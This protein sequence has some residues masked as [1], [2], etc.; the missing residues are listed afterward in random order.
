MISREYRELISKCG[1]IIALGGEHLVSLPLIEAQHEKHGTDLFVVQFDAHAD[2]RKEYLGVSLTH[3][4]VM[5]KA[6]DLIG[7]ERIAA[8]GIRSGTD[9]EWAELRNHPHVFGALAPRPL[10]AFPEFA[11]KHLKGRKVYLTIDLDV[12]D[13][14]CMPGT[15]TPE[16]GGISFGDAVQILRALADAGIDIVGADIVELAPDY[17]HSGIS[18]ALAAT[19]LRELILLIGLP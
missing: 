14:A 16:P 19:L 11:R 5:R 4:S 18:A 2:L 3:C 10:G 9:R 7:A 17:D 15:G 8:I 6:T 13:P 12:F 1:R